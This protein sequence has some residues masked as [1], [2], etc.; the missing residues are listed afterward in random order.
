MNDEAVSIVCRSMGYA[1]GAKGSAECSIYRGESHCGA[2]GSGVAMNDLR[3]TGDELSVHFV[4]CCGLG[5]VGHVTLQGEIID[6]CF[7]F[8]DDRPFD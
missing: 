5:H 4:C 1:C 7:H 3:C 6:V 8:N 2:S